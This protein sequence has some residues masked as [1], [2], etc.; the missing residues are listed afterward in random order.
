VTLG[1][2]VINNRD[3]IVSQP[4]SGYSITY[5]RDGEA[6]MLIAIDG[7]GRT[8]DPSE[9]YFWAKAWKAA[10]S[11]ILLQRTTLIGTRDGDGV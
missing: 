9:V 5:R 6:P 3:I 1:V 8:D 10:H 11:P 7:I 4:E 2:E